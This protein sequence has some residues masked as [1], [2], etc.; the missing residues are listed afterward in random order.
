LEKRATDAAGAASGRKQR[1]T[2]RSG[3]ANSA[4][5]QESMN[6]STAPHFN[7][8]QPGGGELHLTIIALTLNG[9]PGLNERL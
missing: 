2:A 6:G 4:C 1:C 3:A 9:Q 8:R 5:V 7:S